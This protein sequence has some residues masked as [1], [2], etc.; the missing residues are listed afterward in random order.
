MDLGKNASTV[1]IVIIAVVCIVAVTIL[2]IFAP[3]SSNVGV[4]VTL[5]GLFVSNL[6]QG[7]STSN[8]VREV[9]DLVNSKMTDLVTANKIVDTEAGHKQGVADEKAASGRW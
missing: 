5:A 1:G 3:A 2:S 7:Q 4:I 9:H 8:K 6:I